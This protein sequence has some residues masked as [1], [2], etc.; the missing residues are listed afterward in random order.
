MWRICFFN[1]LKSSKDRT[2]LPDGKEAEQAQRRAATETAAF[3]WVF[4][5]YDESSF[6]LENDFEINPASTQTWATH[7]AHLDNHMGQIWAYEIIIIIIWGPYGFCP[8][9]LY[10]SH[11]G[12]PLPIWVTDPAHSFHISCPQFH[13][14]GPHTVFVHLLHMGPKWVANMQYGSHVWCQYGSQILPTFPPDHAYFSAFK[15]TVRFLSAR[16][17]R[18]PRGVPNRVPVPGEME[19]CTSSRIKYWNVVTSFV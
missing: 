9:A 11:V 17:I 10:G 2:K 6:H 16:F 15:G 14:Y 13:P 7:G 5:Y 8:P 12:C 4:R 18:V 1:N 3:I 19:H